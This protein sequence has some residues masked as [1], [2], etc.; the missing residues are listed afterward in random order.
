MKSKLFFLIVLLLS[1]ELLS[2]SNN[3]TIRTVNIPE[4][5]ITKNKTTKTEKKLKI[6]WLLKKD[7]ELLTYIKNEMET[8][9][10]IRE[11]IFRVANISKKK[12]SI[13]FVIYSSKDN[14]ADKEIYSKEIVLN[15]KEEANKISFINKNKLMKK[16][17]IFIGFRFSERIDNKGVYVYTE[18]SKNQPMTYIRKEQKCT[19]FF[20]ENSFLPEKYRKINIYLKIK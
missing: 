5:I 19:L 15:P 14:L 10:D 20:N 17:G 12:S 4:V 7:E 1:V 16:D 2:Q 3:D 11:I 9:Q 13:K 6:K 18:T 8:N